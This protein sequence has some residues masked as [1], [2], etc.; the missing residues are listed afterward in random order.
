MPLSQ[1]VLSCLENVLASAQ[2]SR[3]KRISR[4]LQFLVDET[5]NGRAEELRERRIGIEVF[6]QPDDWDP[7]VNNIVRSEARRLR[8]KL[9]SYYQSAGRHDAIH[10]EIPRGGYAA[11]FTEIV[12]TATS[13]LKQE[14]T[15]LQAAGSAIAVPPKTNWSL[16]ALLAAAVL[17]PLILALS[18][19]APSWHASAK[20]TDD[21]FEVLPF[22]NEIGQEFS[23]AVSPD[24]KRIAYVW[25]GNGNNYD[26]YIKDVAKGSR[27]RLTRNSAPDISPSWS[28]DGTQVAFLRVLPDHEQVIL[29]P[30]TGGPERVLAEVSSPISSWAADSN[31][32][33]GCYGPV[34]SPRGDEIVVSDQEKPGGRYELFAVSVSNGR[35]TELTHPPGDVRDFCPRFSPDGSRIAFVRAISHGISDLH[36]ISSHGGEDRQLT[37][38]RRAIRGLNWT[39]DGQDIVF[40]SLHFSSFQLRE[41]A[42]DGGASWQLPVTAT[43]VV[44]PA[45]APDG[46]WMAFTELEDNWNI[47]RARLTP[48]GLGKPELFL[49]SSGRNHTPIYSPDGKHIAFVSDRSGSPEI[50]LADENGL[51]LRKLTSLDT[52][53]LGGTRWSPDG[54]T[55]IFDARTTGHSSI[56]TQRLAAGG[57]VAVVQDQYEERSPSWSH[58]G[59]S[60]YF[61]SWR[62]GRLQTWRLSRIGG[63][64]Q[65]IGPLN[66]NIALESTDGRSIFFS[67]NNAEIWKCNTD[68]S[69][70]QRLPLS[71]PPDPGMDWMLGPKGIYFAGYEGDRPAFYFYDLAKGTTTRIGYPDRALSPGTAGLTVSPDGKW[72]L[73]SQL[74]HLSTDVSI[75]RSIPGKSRK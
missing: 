43:S 54:S 11:T 58:D 59:R 6:D 75:R 68:G 49:S 41:I 65:P 27:I 15:P 71:V 47:W 3:A 14:A 22:A 12:Q 18:Y 50:W 28:P 19:L 7:K 2:F 40:S 73:Y 16:R 33:F 42:A 21:N 30:V 69:D 56:F 66:A 8:S 24:G 29:A 51:N 9:E 37:F 52:P 13:P 67:T 17:V 63:Q 60:I 57:P 10:I 61:N 39:P 31:P 62:N 20:A 48:H 53:W 72:L 4:F 36:T 1:T 74:D 32:Y 46:R 44:D 34:W 70:L 23:P 5:L 55:I 45:P 35:R 64:L 25:D 38:D 26:I